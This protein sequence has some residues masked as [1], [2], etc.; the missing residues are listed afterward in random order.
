M[1]SLS[2]LLYPYS[3][4]TFKS[5]FASERGGGQKPRASG[6]LSLARGSE[7]SPSGKKNRTVSGGKVGKGGL[8]GS[9]LGELAA[10]AD[11]VVDED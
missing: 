3:H 10:G 2:F 9:E 11:D 4:L 1:P 7:S 5:F 8:R 6:F